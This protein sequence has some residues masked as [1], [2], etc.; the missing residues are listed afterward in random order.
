MLTV[1]P[2]A[3]SRSRLG[4]SVLDV[5]LARMA[6]VASPTFPP[7]C[8]PSIL[9]RNTVGTSERGL[10][11]DGCDYCTEFKGGMSRQTSPTDSGRELLADQTKTQLYRSNIFHTISLRLFVA[12]AFSVLVSALACR[13]MANS[14][15]PS[16]PVTDR[17]V[18][19]KPCALPQLPILRRSKVIAA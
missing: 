4:R 1:C 12:I 7:H 15:Q 18:T 13:E 11:Y 9:L 17:P 3:A 6:R 14:I 19:G 16:Y 10:V 8:S 2:P 5:L